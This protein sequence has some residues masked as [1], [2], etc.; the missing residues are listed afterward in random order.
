MGSVPRCWLPVG[1]SEA[2]TD[3]GGCEPYTTEHAGADPRWWTGQPVKL[4]FVAG[5]ERTGTQRRMEL[6]PS[7]PQCCVSGLHGTVT[8]AE[9]RLSRTT[10]LPMLTTPIWPCR[11]PQSRDLF[12]E[13]PYRA[14]VRGRAGKGRLA[15]F[16]NQPCSALLSLFFFFLARSLP[17][18]V[19]IARQRAKSSSIPSRPSTH[20][21]RLD[22]ESRPR[23]HR[24]HGWLLRA[25]N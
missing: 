22:L 15:A 6:W 25:Q 14:P 1:S 7:S 4:Q 9:R 10:P 12:P 13:E 24:K 16:W 8:S 18:C 23:W 3:E 17:A 11:T 5:L 19:L 2:R 21:L 20:T